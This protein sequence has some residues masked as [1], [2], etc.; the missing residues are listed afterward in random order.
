MVDQFPVMWRTKMS[1]H[2]SFRLRLSLGLL[3]LVAL[4]ARGDSGGVDRSC[5]DQVLAQ[6]VPAWKKAA[7]VEDDI[8]VV[9]HAKVEERY[10]KDKVSSM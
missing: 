8:Q 1:A 10:V 3:F 9:C 7:S 5:V 4:A 6:G 2:R